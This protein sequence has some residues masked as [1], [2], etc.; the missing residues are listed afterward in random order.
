MGYFHSSAVSLPLF[1]IWHGPSRFSRYPIS[2]LTRRQVP[3]R[4]QKVNGWASV[5]PSRWS[6]ICIVPERQRLAQEQLLSAR[7]LQSMEW[8]VRTEAEKYAARDL[9]ICGV[10]REVLRYRM[11]VSEG[12]L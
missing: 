4:G 6:P 5:S 2:P 11:R 7:R 3:P 9:V 1:I 12:A 8:T 10:H